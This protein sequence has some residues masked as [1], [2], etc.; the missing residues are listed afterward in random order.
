MVSPM[1]RLVFLA[2]SGACCVGAGLRADVIEYLD[3]AEW[4]LGAGDYTTIDFTGFAEGTK[5]T[6]QYADLG[7]LFGSDIAIHLSSF[8]DGAGLFG[9]GGGS[10]AIEIWFAEPVTAVAVDLL[11]D[12]QFELYQGEQLAY[13]STVFG[14]PVPSFAGLISSEPFDAVKILDPFDSEVFIDNLYFAPP[15]PGPSVL[16]LLG[17]VFVGIVRRRRG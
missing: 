6:D 3:K 10:S 17:V 15:I 11:G 7:V 13:S 1:S 14:E 2:C 12:V 8:Q 4:Q 5:I 16:A 9:G